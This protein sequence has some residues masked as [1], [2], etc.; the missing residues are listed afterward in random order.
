VPNRR[1]PL[2]RTRCAK[3]TASRSLQDFDLSISQAPVCS[4]VP[5]DEGERQYGCAPGSAGPFLLARSWD[6]RAGFC[7]SRWHGPASLAWRGFPGAGAGMRMLPEDQNRQSA[8]PVL[9]PEEQEVAMPWFP[10]FASAVELARRQTRAAGLADP[11]GEYFTALNQGDAHA[12]ETVWPGEVV[13]YDPRAGEVRGHRQVRRFIS[14]NLS[15]L[16]GLHARTE[17]VAATS[18]GGRAVV[19]LLARLDHGGGG[20]GVAGGGRR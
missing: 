12:L 4:K 8:G 3:L 16:A 7:L 17:R 18:A 2:I 9:P 11:V 15:W 20:A 19:E 1:E 6:R 14:R 5:A 13:I 10:D